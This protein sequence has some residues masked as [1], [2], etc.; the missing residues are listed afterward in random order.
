MLGYVGTVK[1]G[2]Y[3]DFLTDNEGYIRESLFENNIRDYQGSVDVNNKIKQTLE[4]SFDKDFWWLNNG[5]TIIAT[6]PSL[7]SKKL[8][9]ENIQI[10]N[11]LQTSYSIFKY[12]NGDSQDDRSVLVKILI[13]DDKETIDSIIE[14]TNSQNPVSPSLLRA[15]DKIQRDIEQYF[16]NSGYYYD[17]RKNYYKNQGKPASR[18]FSIQSTAQSIESILFS[19][20]NVA[21]SKPTSL[22]KDDLA[23]NRIFDPRKDFKIYLNCCLILKRT[24][25]F[26]SQISDVKY[27][28]LFSNFKLHL[29]R[30]AASISMNKVEITDEDL[31]SFNVQDYSQDDFENACQTLENS[32]HEYFAM[33]KVN[34]INMAKQK[35]FTELLIGKI[36]EGL[37]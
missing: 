36:N 9:V 8:S 32:I 23:Y 14:S 6:N 2:D 34:V 20:P 3:K 11:G 19:S 30:I 10:V 22:I 15:T 4:S 28:D 25:E 29:A 5:I 35:R 26:W 7:F 27:K 21:R 12:H 17:R 18:I 1:L 13:S 16:F 33:E 24:N 31:S 37:G